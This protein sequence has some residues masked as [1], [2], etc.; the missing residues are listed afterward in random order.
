M[1]K[2]RTS[3]IDLQ[4]RQKDQKIDHRKLYTVMFHAVTDAIEH[5][6][7]MDF[8]QALKVLKEAQIRTEELYITTDET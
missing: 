5:M 2:R 3:I 8:G 4:E 1:R 7:H 6:E